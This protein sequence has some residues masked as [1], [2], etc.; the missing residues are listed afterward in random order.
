M[1]ARGVH[2]V[3]TA[4][5]EPPVKI[6]FVAP[7]WRENVVG[8]LLT[9]FKEVC[10]RSELL[11]GSWKK[12]WEESHHKLT[13]KNGS[14]IQFKTY[15]E[16]LDTFGGADLDAV[17]LDEHCPEPIYRECRARLTDRRGFLCCS[18][19]PEEGMTWEED[20]VLDPPV[21]ITIDHWFFDVR[22]NP[23]LD[24]EGVKQ[25]L[26]GLEGTIY[27]DTK[28]KGQFTPLSGRVIPQWNPKVHIVPDYEI[29]AHWPRGICID[30]HRRTPCAC[31][32]VAWSP[33]GVCVVYRTAKKFMTVPE[34]QK[35]IIAQTGEEN[36]D[37][38]LLDQ[39]GEGEGV[40]IDEKESLLNQF[41]GG[42]NGL[43]FELV[44]KDS[45]QFFNSGIFKLWDMFKVRKTGSPK[46]KIQI[47]ESCNYGVEQ[48]NGQPAGSLAWELNRYVY[49][50][51]QKSDEEQLREKVRKVNDHLIDDLRYLVMAGPTNI[52]PANQGPMIVKP[53]GR[54]SKY[55]GYL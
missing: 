48:I 6:R 49:K 43:P 23:H 31:M 5:R 4:H 18:M 29:P 34:W 40:N 44:K 20:H 8:V 39:P 47:F 46:T 21:G 33:E 55:T 7:K 27:Y 12:A 53:R 54:K 35:Y 50:K 2:P 15:E 24:P 37:T 19:T 45:E 16:D 1:F 28:V 3:R 36:I 51:K 25:F 42:T 11:G 26:A 32:W 9:K 38:W 30:A 22:G 13:Y 52:E 14:T 41:T 10:I 17:Y